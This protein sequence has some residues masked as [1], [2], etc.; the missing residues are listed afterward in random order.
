MND[1]FLSSGPNALFSVL[2]EL[3]GQAMARP[4]FLI[5]SAT[6]LFSVCGLYAMFGGLLERKIIARAHSRYGPMYTGPG[7]SLQTLADA[8][9]FLQKEMIF[10]KGSDGLLYRLSPLLLVVTPFLAV[11]LLPIGS[12]ALVNSSYS[13]LLV[14]ALLSLGPILI[15]WGAWSSNSKYST[16]GGLRAAAMTMSYEVLLVVSLASIILTV[17]SAN[18][19]DIVAYQ[20]AH[21]MWMAALQP[22]A[23]VLF[24]IALIASVERNPFDLVEAESEL[25]S[26]WKTE[27]GGVYFSITLLAEYIKLLVGCILCASIFLGGS[28][29][30]LGDI[31]FLL[32]VALLTIL[33]FYVRATAIRLRLDQIFSVVWKKLIPLGLVNIIVTA[34][35]FSLF[36]GRL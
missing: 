17:G 9:K 31:G 21:G 35:I 30:V 12:F 32:K 29:T 24:L 36:G 1:S 26:G 27:Y 2:E 11:P 28:G 7:G 20:S 13:L 14:L 23:F 18:I 8:L 6:F 33:M 4:L 16:L 3:L 34:L 19:L 5:L 15:L 10:P 22:F 25:V